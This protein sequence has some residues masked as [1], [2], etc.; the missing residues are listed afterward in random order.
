M[1]R[2]SSHDRV[3]HHRG[4]EQREVRR[5]RDDA[6]V[7]QRVVGQR[8]VG[9]EP[10]ELLGLAGA[11]RRARASAAA[12]RPGG[13]DRALADASTPMASGPKRS[14]V[15]ARAARGTSAARRDR[16]TGGIGY[17]CSGPVSATWNEAERLKMACPCWIATTRRVVKR[18]A[19]ADAVD[20]EDDRDAAGRRA[21]GSRRAASARGR[22]GSTV[23]PAAIS[24]C[25][26]TCPP[27]TR[28]RSSSG[29]T[30][31]NRFT[32][33]CSSSSRSIRS[34]SA[35]PIGLRPGRGTH[36][37]RRRVAAVPSAEQR[38]SPT[39]VARRHTGRAGRGGYPKNTAASSKRRRSTVL[40]VRDRVADRDPDDVGAVQRDHRRRS[41]PSCTA[42]I[43]SSPKRVARI[44][45]NAVG[46]PPRRTWPRMR[47]ARLVAGALPR[48]RV[49]SGAADPAEAHVPE[50]VDAG[51]LD[52]E[53]R[54]LTGSRPSATT[55]IEKLAPRACRC[56]SRSQTSSMSNGVSGT[57]MTSAPPA[58]PGV[59]RDPPGVAAHDLDDHHPVVAL[60][61]GVQPV[62]GVGRD[63]HRGVEPEG[64]VGLRQ[65]VVDRLGNADDC[66]P[67][68]SASC[69]ATPSV[70]SPP[71]DDQR[72]DV[73]AG[74]RATA[75]RRGRRRVW[76]GFVRDVPSIVPPR[77]QQPPGGRDGR[78]RLRSPSST[79]RQPWRYPTSWWP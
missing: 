59:G 61:G 16:A 74:Q 2:S 11:R 60:G 3:R 47:D 1:K 31:R 8:A 22:S 42:S 12:R 43:A 19:V 6:R 25:A 71:I 40:S 79:P 18:V 49:C 9:A 75:P 26:A 45:S 23:R 65:V 58:S 28:W 48:S 14:S 78:A 37:E 33:S 77:R 35:E 52:G 13:V 39:S 53:A 21:A 38:R 62:D 69:A 32:S 56:W 17:W 72:V 27:N 67:R 66:A 44:R 63:L 4:V 7:Q 30:P 68:R 50:L 51:A 41:R 10:H 57:R 24:A 55:T 5:V 64:E 34:S 20:V 29:L 76:S 15:A 70:S 36:R 46:V 73:V 54:A